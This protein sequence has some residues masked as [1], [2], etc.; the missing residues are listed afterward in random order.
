MRK[1]LRNRNGKKYMSNLI[2]RTHQT[3][4][5]TL[6]SPDPV[7]DIP[8]TRLE[9]PVERTEYGP[10]R[11]CRPVVTPVNTLKGVRDGLLGKDGLPGVHAGRDDGLVGE[12]G[13]GD[14]G[15]VDAGV[16]VDD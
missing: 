6:T 15:G 8:E 4:F 13:G 1:A 11:L 10:P 14:Q 12:G 2:K 3:F 16:G 9:P 7:P 5:C